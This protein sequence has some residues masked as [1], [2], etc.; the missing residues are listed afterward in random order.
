MSAQQRIPAAW[1]PVG[2][3]LPLATFAGGCFW[4]VELAFQRQPGVVDSCVGYCAGHKAD[5]TYEEVCSG[6]TGHTEAV[7]V[8]YNDKE[9][10]YGELVDLLFSRIDPT[11]LNRQGNDVGSQYRSGIYT[12]SSEQQSIAE[13]KK[14]AIP[15]CVTEVKPIDKFWP[16]EEY[17]QQYLSKG[18]RMGSAQSAAKGC[19]DRIRCYG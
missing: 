18:G 5:P 15:G 6:R 4:G 2:N 13:Q 7:Q 11:A 9:V 14:A 10:S 12:H 16:A 19:K 3:R 17:H 1:P 8:T